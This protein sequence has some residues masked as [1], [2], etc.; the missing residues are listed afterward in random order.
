[1]QETFTGQGNFAAQPY[2]ILKGLRTAKFRRDWEISQP[3]LNCQGLLHLSVMLPVL[4]FS[5]LIPIDFFMLEM[6][7]YLWNK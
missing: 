5:A 1:M 6:N 7:P 2:E 4:P 3:L